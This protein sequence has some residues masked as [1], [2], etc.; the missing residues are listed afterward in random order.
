DLPIGIFASL[1]ICTV[2]YISVAA[3]LT[4]LVPYSQIDIRAPRAE[5]LRIAGFQWGA[6]IVATGA[7]AGITSVLVVMMLGQIRVFFAMSRD[8]LLRPWLC[9]EHTR[10]CQ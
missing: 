5:G 4:G 7:V 10:Y 9:T 6:A 2:L 8:H 3:V 1:G